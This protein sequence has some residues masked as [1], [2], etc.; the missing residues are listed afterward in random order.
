MNHR[1]N[2]VEIRPESK[3]AVFEKL[4]SPNGERVVFEVLTQYFDY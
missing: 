4:D 3:E 1:H 2:L